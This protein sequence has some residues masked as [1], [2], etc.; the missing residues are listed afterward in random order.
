M[1]SIFSVYDSVLSK[2]GKD[3]YIVGKMLKSQLCT[4]H[5]AYKLDLFENV[6][7]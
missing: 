5:H 4:I 3:W 7:V 6:L 1:V 2:I